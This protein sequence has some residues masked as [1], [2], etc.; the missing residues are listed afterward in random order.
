MSSGGNLVDATSPQVFVNSSLTSASLEE[1]Q[2][3]DLER[4]RPMLT[5]GNTTCSLHLRYHAYTNATLP[6][7]LQRPQNYQ[8]GSCT[9]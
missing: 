4:F 8:G 2:K 1:A 9:F 3:Q 5:D 7:L 6:T